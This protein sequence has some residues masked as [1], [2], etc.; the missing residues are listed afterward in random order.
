VC[1]SSRR[2][3]P[4]A[5]STRRRR[6]RRRHTA[7]PGDRAPAASQRKDRAVHVV[8]RPQPATQGH[9]RPSPRRTA[10]GRPHGPIPR[11]HKARARAARGGCRGRA[12]RGYS[13]GKACRWRLRRTRR[14][15]STP[16]SRRVRRVL[17]SHRKRTSSRVQALL[18]PL[19][20]PLRAL[21]ACCGLVLAQAQRPCNC[22]GDDRDH[23][24]ARPHA[25]S[26]RSLLLPSSTDTE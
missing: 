26:H 15:A 3:R 11:V 4:R 25:N 10:N 9:A 7:T 21:A 22:R 24:P 6:R 2:H 16:R 14:P 17:R 23:G 13:G 19:L 20:P 1:R 12:R 8:E 18:W 5:S